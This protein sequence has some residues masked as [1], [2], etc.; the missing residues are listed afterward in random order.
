MPD[1]PECSGALGKYAIKHLQG[2]YIEYMASLKQV[3][4]L[5]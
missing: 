3:L 4:R 2:S 5:W 1:K